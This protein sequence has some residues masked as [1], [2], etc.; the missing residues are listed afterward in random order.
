MLMIWSQCETI[1]LQYTKVGSS[2]VESVMAQRSEA[3][4]MM[5]RLAGDLLHG[6]SIIQRSPTT[7]ILPD[8]P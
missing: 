5:K 3:L 1:G 7:P 6:F 4:P 8:L 2:V